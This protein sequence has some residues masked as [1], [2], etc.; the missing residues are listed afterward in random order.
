MENLKNFLKSKTFSKILVGL[1]AVLVVLTIFQAG[2]M[3]GY[4]KAAFS[5]RWGDN[6]YKMF[7]GPRKDLL[8]GFPRNDFPNAHGVVG[9]IIKV[10]LPKIFVEGDDGIEKVV[11]IATSTAIRRLKDPVS[12]ADLK[13]DDSVIVIGAPNNDSIIEARLI[14]ILPKP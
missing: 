11:E 13:T 8:P 12:S 10:E 7:G 5:Y 3:V 6:Y 9:S 4:R 2:V 14:R 1:G